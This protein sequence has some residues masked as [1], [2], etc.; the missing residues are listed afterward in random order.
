[1]NINWKAIYLLTA[2]S[3]GATIGVPANVVVY[4]SKAVQEVFESPSPKPYGREDSKSLGRSNNNT[5]IQVG[6]ISS[7][8]DTFFKV[9]LQPDTLGHYSIA[10]ML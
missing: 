5:N 9:S 1:M 7:G 8:P 2:I 4:I 10:G 6:P 3:V